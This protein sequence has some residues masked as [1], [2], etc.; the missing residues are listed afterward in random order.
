MNGGHNH[1]HDAGVF[2]TRLVVGYQVRPSIFALKCVK[3]GGRIF[4]MKVQ[5]CLKQLLIISNNILCLKGCSHN[6]KKEEV[7]TSKIMEGE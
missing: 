3:L 1:S 6:E 7:S 4:W 5:R 2:I